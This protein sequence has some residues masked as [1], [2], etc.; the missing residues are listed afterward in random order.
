[1]VM[2]GKQILIKWGIFVE[3][4]CS[5]NSIAKVKWDETKE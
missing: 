1:M 3:S 4:K 5:T 2:C